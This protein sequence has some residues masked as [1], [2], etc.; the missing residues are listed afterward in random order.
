[1]QVT[2]QV[3]SLGTGI[4]LLCQEETKGKNLAKEGVKF[5]PS[6]FQ[7]FAFAFT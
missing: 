5:V 3:Y 2:L 1:M 4:N 7:T 6:P